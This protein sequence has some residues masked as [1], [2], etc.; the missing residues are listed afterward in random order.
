MLITQE[1]I[2]YFWGGQG[3]LERTTNLHAET[4][5]PVRLPPPRMSSADVM[6]RQMTSL[7]GNQGNVCDLLKPFAE[8]TNLYRVRNMSYDRDT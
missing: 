2:N 3:L 7:M 1:I 4:F 6:E 5:M 8:V